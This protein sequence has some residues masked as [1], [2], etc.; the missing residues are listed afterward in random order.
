MTTRGI[1]MPLV[2]D[3]QCK[4]KNTPRVDGARRGHKPIFCNYSW[5]KKTQLEVWKA[6]FRSRAG[7]HVF[8]HDGG[9]VGGR[10]AFSKK[11]RLS[12]KLV[13]FQ[14]E[15]QT[16]QYESYIHS[17]EGKVRA[18]GANDPTDTRKAGWR[19]HRVWILHQARHVVAGLHS[20]MQK[21]VRCAV[22]AKTASQAL[23]D[24]CK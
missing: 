24:T 2:A 21:V 19:K 3:I 17:L 6:F 7:V 10:L 23:P 9:R 8:D 14:M 22:S 20:D 1:S 15:R 5:I 12:K 11:H 4:E 13:S 16:T 18:D